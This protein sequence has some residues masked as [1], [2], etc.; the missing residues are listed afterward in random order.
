M[1]YGCRMAGLL[2]SKITKKSE[3]I[4]ETPTLR[5]D[6]LE[7]TPTLGL[8]EPEKTPTMESV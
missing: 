1:F 8:D 3:R 5:L 2:T 7:K 6:E 4:E